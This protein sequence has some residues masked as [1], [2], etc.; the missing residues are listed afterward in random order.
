MYTQ[1]YDMQMRGRGLY[2]GF[3]GGVGT[4]G[5]EELEEHPLSQ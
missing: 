1:G 2:H 4:S 3:L 5:R